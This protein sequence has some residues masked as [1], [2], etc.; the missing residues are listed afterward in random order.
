MTQDYHFDAE[1]LDQADSTNPGLTV[2]NIC[3]SS[4]ISAQGPFLDLRF[5]LKSAS[6]FELTPQLPLPLKGLKFPIK[7]INFDQ[8]D[9]LGWGV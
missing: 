9:N 6:G 7:M 5:K 1:V 3:H 8:V 4:N 2:N